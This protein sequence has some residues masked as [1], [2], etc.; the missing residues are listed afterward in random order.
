MTIC[1][2]VDIDVASSDIIGNIK[3]PEKK[4]DKQLYDINTVCKMLG[5]TSRT[6]RF[7]EEKGIICSEKVMSGRRQ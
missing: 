3:D 4:M 7:W 2:S 6:L 5:V 1:F